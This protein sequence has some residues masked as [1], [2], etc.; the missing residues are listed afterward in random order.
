METRSLD[1][2]Q[3]KQIY[4]THMKEDFP[5]DE[6]RPWKWFAAMWDQG[7]YESLA[8]YDEDNLVAY[9]FFVKKPGFSYVLLDYLAVCR[10]FRGGG[11]GSR[12]LALMREY[13]AGLDGIMLECEAVSGAGDD[14]ERRMRQ[15]RIGFYV[16]NGAV[17]TGA[18]CR[19]FGIHFSILMYPVGEKKMIPEA[20]PAIMDEIY[21]VMY[22]PEAYRKKVSL[23]EDC[24]TRGLLA[25]LGLEH[26]IPR[27]I[28]LVGG[29]GKT[30]VMYRLAG[31]LA[32]LGKRVIVT[33]STHIRRPKDLPVKTPDCAPQLEGQCRKGEILVVG[34]EAGDGKLKG[35]SVRET[36]RLA[37]FCDVLLIE[38][39][40]AKCLPFKFPAAHEPVIIPET[41]LVIACAGL[42]CIGRPFGEVC[43]RTEE[44]CRFLNKGPEEPVQPEDVAAVLCSPEGGRKA[45]KGEF[46]LLLNKADGEAGVRTAEKVMSCIRREYNGITAVT[47][48]DEGNME[49]ALKGGPWKGD[50][51]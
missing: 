13:F 31:E 1:L 19:M 29:G 46:R 38:A 36:G 5:A 21:R 6:I 20:A 9:A 49:L 40:G 39:D 8:L 28:S 24:T 10:E 26:E 44:A 45:V 17:A 27:V 35:L 42:D 11:Y 2:Q 16:R 12:F 37:G 48:F 4:D 15:R 22:A 34:T 25:A 50:W 32:E 7:T 3:T 14:E 51:D 41:E 30:T 23:W 18:W 43:F 47:S 33:T